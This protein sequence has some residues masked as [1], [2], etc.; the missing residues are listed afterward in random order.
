MTCWPTYAK[1]GKIELLSPTHVDDFET[2]SPA[3]PP[4]KGLFALRGEWLGG[5]HVAAVDAG[6]N[7]PPY[8]LSA[9]PI[10]PNHCAL[11]TNEV[12]VAVPPSPRGRK[13]VLRD[14]RCSP[15]RSL[16]ARGYGHGGDVRDRGSH[17]A[18]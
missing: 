6:P 4:S 9:N 11:Q 14:G 3:T 17:A 10:K 13:C 5:G 2:P 12:P 15:A 18:I 16:K 1:P 8:D 7:I